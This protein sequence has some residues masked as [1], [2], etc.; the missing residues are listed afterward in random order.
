[1]SFLDFFK[2]KRPEQPRVLEPEA[3]SEAPRIIMPGDDDYDAKPKA[4][5]AQIGGRSKLD[6]DLAARSELRRRVTPASAPEAR[7]DKPKR[8]MWVRYSRS[9]GILVDLL[10]GDIAK[11][12]LVDRDGF[13]MMDVTVLAK[14]V[15][16]ATFDEIPE[17]RRGQMT[18]EDAARLGY[19]REI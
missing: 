11:V 18:P 6:A 7:S 8:G 5:I 15:R 17:A 14:E 16:Q 2:S 10:P 13:N 9:A 4:H 3:D 19:T 12:M 1:V